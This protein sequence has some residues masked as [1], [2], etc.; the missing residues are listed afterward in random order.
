M[1]INAKQR[2][3]ELLEHIEFPTL[4]YNYETNRILGMNSF[5]LKILGNQKRNIK[6]LTVEMK[7][8]KYAKDLLENGSHIFYKQEIYNGIKNVEL[9]IEV[10]VITVDNQHLCIVFFQHSFKDNFGKNLWVEVPRAYWKNKEQEYLGVNK[11]L[12]KDFGIDINKFRQ[13]RNEDFLDSEVATMINIEEMRILKGKESIFDIIQNIKTVNNVS[14]FTKNHKIPI[15]NRN[16]TVIGIFGVYQLILDRT[17]YKENY[18]KALKDSYEFYLKQQLKHNFLSDL[19]WLTLLDKDI[20][21]I[22]DDMFHKIVNYCGI[23]FINISRYHSGNIRIEYRYESDNKCGLT[24]TKTHNEAYTKFYNRI[25]RIINKEGMIVLNA[26][27]HSQEMFREN[28]ENLN[29]ILQNDDWNALLLFDFNSND[30]SGSVICFGKMKEGC[31]WTTEEISLLKVVT[32]L[33]K[34]IFQK[35]VLTQ[36]VE[37]LQV[38][39]EELNHKLQNKS[40]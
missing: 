20:N 30:F 12:E 22:L 8:P 17:A 34:S 39:I 37:K 5:A 9:D 11:N 24:I 15:L 1:R 28:T 4:I 6:V 31:E 27:E 10:N 26:N 25:A 40:N 38:D 18:N 29:N 19:L 3:K 35:H 2:Y 33:I 32:Q 16:G 21:I 23:D 36:E 14:Y 7:R 13:I